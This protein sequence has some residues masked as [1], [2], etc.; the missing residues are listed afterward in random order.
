M[1]CTALKVIP[2][3]VN[4]YFLFLDQFPH[5]RRASRHPAGCGAVDRRCCSQTP[6]GTLRHWRTSVT[7]GEEL[8]M[9]AKQLPLVKQSPFWKAGD[10]SKK[11][12][13]LWRWG[14][15]SHVHYRPQDFQ[16]LAGT[17][18]SPSLLQLPTQA[19]PHIISM[20][21]KNHWL[22]LEMFMDVGKS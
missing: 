15:A 3:N 14:W 22:W 21:A 10:G 9:Q 1:V 4:S 16:K 8:L 11:T 19:R 13:L 18:S 20:A 17:V 6:T 12:L 5:L 7:L 2:R